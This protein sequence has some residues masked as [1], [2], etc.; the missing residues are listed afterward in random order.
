MPRSLRRVIGRSKKRLAPSRYQNNNSRKRVFNEIYCAFSFRKNMH[1][2]L[3]TCFIGSDLLVVAYSQ[4]GIMITGVTIDSTVAGGPAFN[5]KK[6]SRGDV[7]LKVDGTSVTNENI[8]QLLVGRD[9]PGSSVEI[10]VAKGGSQAMT[11]RSS[12]SLN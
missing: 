1:G 9:V 6:L 10:C 11:L 5:S 3:G 7:I 2:V 4:V 12:G 8:F